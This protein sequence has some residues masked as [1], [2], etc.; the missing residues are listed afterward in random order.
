MNAITHHATPVTARER[1]TFSEH[2]ALMADK[3]KARAR[4]LGIPTKLLDSGSRSEQAA[5][6]EAIHIAWYKNESVKE[7]RAE[8]DSTKEYR[9]SKVPPV[10]GAIVAAL[11]AVAV[12][13]L[14]GGARGAAAGVA[15]ITMGSA[16]A[17]FGHVTLTD[18]SIDRLEDRLE[19]RIASKDRAVER[20]REIGKPS[21]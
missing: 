14:L 11:P 16:M 8:L 10:A 2:T 4:S 21:G 7:T 12:T 19:T 9:S 5:L 6:R 18:A 3:R 1:P 15:I 13:A 20:A 17:H